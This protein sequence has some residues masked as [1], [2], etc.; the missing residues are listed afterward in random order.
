MHN[1]KQCNIITLFYKRGDLVKFVIPRFRHGIAVGTDLVTAS[2]ECEVN[3]R[4][5]WYYAREDAGELHL[6]L[7]T[8]LIPVGE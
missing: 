7:W 8:D 3:G 4:P 1:T 6:V 5:G 2:I